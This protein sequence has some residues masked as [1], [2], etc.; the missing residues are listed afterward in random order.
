MGIVALAGIGLGVVGALLY[1]W[2]REKLIVAVLATTPP[3]GRIVDR[4]RGAVLEVS[5]TAATGRRSTA[6]SAPVGRATR[7][8]GRW[9]RYGHA[10]HGAVSPGRTTPAADWEG[11]RG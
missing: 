9:S 5:I 4:R 3:G 2:R 7:G 1:E 6:G 11:N 8:P 10:G